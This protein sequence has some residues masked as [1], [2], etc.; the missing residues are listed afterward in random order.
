MNECDGFD[1][2]LTRTNVTEARKELRITIPL[3]SNYDDDVM[4]MMVII[5]YLN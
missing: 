4:E 1:F 2:S 5:F 3:I